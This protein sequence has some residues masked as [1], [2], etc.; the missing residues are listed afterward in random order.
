V[1]MTKPFKWFM[2]TLCDEMLYLYIH[3]RNFALRDSGIQVWGPI[4]ASKH[5]FKKK[6]AQLTLFE[7]VLF[8][9]LQEGYLNCGAFFL[10]AA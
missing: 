3:L 7:L 6:L 5:F 9:H 2:G 4:E 1:S 8:Y 10:G